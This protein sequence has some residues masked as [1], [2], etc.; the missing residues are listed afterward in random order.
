MCIYSHLFSTQ[1]GMSEHLIALMLVFLACGWTTVNLH[2]L[3]QSVSST[4]QK[5]AA[6][7]GGQGDFDLAGACLQLTKSLLQNPKIKR[8]AKNL[9]KQLSSPAKNMFRKISLGSVF[10]LSLSFITLVLEMMGRRYHDEFSQFHDHEHWP[11]KCILML[12][13][14]LWFIFIFGAYTTYSGCKG[15]LRTSMANVALFGSIWLLAFPISV[16]IADMLPARLRHRVVSIGSVG[17]QIV[18]LQYLVYLC[19]FSKSFTKFSSIADPK[20]GSMLPDKLT[21]L[22]DG[23]N[24]MKAGQAH[25]RKVF[26]VA[27]D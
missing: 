24:P 27:Y 15:E 8:F 18:A 12:R 3:V 14:I 6:P 23:N 22:D 5:P 13:V 20:K 2:D 1:Q 7:P 4:I 9:A 11:G 17:L 19:F 25:K 26:K 10:V 16:L 21:S